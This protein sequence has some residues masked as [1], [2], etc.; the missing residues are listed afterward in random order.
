MTSTMHQIVAGPSLDELFDALRF[1][2][3]GRQV[4]L[5][6]SPETPASANSK[7][8]NLDFKAHVTQLSPEDGSG[9]NWLFRLTDQ[10]AV[11]GSQYLEGYINVIRREGWVRATKP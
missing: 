10:H 3:E 4:T 9:N 2:H 1:G 11:L 5:T 8:D 6:V 7:P